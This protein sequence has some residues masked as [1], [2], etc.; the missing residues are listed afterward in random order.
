MGDN[1][2]STWKRQALS[3]GGHSPHIK[4]QISSPSQA[5]GTYRRRKDQKLRFTMKLPYDINSAS[6]KSFD[7]TSTTSSSEDQ[8]A[9][10][11]A[12]NETKLVTYSRTIFLVILLAIAAA[13]AVTTYI[14]LSRQEED[15]FE[16]EVKSSRFRFTFDNLLTESITLTLSPFRFWV[17]RCKLQC[18]HNMHFRLSLRTW[19]PGLKLSQHTLLNKRVLVK[20]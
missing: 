18:R 16:A 9:P 3:S 20:K 13:C 15:A 6:S 14:I 7:A 4:Q 10:V 12:R 11:L 2:A 17:R 19:L 5:K 1:A 8:P